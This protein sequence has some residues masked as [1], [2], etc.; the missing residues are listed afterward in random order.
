MFVK[1]CQA[2][3][4]SRDGRCVVRKGR[5]VWY[6]EQVKAL[7]ANGACCK[8]C[9]LS[10]Y[11]CYHVKIA[12]SLASPSKT[13][14]SS[15]THA[16]NAQPHLNTICFPFLPFPLPPSALSSTA[17]P[18]P[19]PPTGPPFGA[20]PPDMPGPHAPT[21]VPVFCLITPAPV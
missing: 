13:T 15:V 10:T 8:S 7:D 4:R 6:G 18:E 1:T 20:L 12:Y 16:Q 14:R 5:P 3:P 21:G 11:R 9:T 19:L 17:A 2:F